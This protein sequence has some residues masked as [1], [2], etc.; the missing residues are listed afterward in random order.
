[1]FGCLILD[2]TSNSLRKWS[3]VCGKELSF[4][5]LYF[6]I[7]TCIPSQLPTNLSSSIFAFLSKCYDKALVAFSI[8]ALSLELTYS[9]PSFSF[10]LSAFIPSSFSGKRFLRNLSSSNWI[11]NFKLVN[12]LMNN[13]SCGEKVQ[14]L[15]MWNSSD[16]KR[17]VRWSARF[18]K[19]FKDWLRCCE[20]ASN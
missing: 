9:C 18:C 13:S 14:S 5:L 20:V 6:V 11:I 2:Y 16:C 19:A 1:M 15:T 7:K 3:T 12:V 17:S 8:L 10:W 4:F